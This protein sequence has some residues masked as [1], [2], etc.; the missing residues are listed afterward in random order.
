MVGGAVEAGG[1]GTIVSGS[2]GARADVLAAIRRAKPQ[3]V[4]DRQADYSGISR[5]YVRQGTLDDAGRLALFTD[6]LQ[7]YNVTV[8]RSSPDRI[9]AT[10][11]ALCA[12]RDVRQL[13]APPALAASLQPPGVQL[14]PDRALSYD[15][16]DRSSGVLTLATVAIAL[17]G[18]IVLTHNSDEGRRA[19]TL[20][21]DYHICVVRAAQI[22]ETVPEA[23]RQ[24][25]A[26]APA[27]VTTISG[28]SA[29]ADIEM[30]R[31]RGVHGPRTLDVIIVEA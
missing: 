8:T 24:L 12:G 31:V 4:A 19:L 22:V 23:M 18:T 17:T 20:V 16:L 29:T 27:L 3:A 25:S 13:V 11:A 14:L 26:L 15:D 28:P 7:H 30:I 10:V 6:R 5:A 21:P 9:A 1:G 2:S